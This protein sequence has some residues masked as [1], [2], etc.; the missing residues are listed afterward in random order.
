ML[1]PRAACRAAS[2]LAALIIDP[3]W[4]PNTLT[5]VSTTVWMINGYSVWGSPTTVLRVAGTVSSKN[6]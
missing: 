2:Q 5:T 3:R 6:D 4:M 1:G